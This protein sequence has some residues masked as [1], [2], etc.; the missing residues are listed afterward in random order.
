LFLLLNG[1][2]LTVS[3]AEC[4]TQMLLLAAGDLSEPGFAAWLRA[5][6]VEMK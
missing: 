5:G 4:V 1:R 6:C 3:D 2:E